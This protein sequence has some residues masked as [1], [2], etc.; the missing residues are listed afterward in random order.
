LLNNVYFDAKKGT[1]KGK[2]SQKLK[3]GPKGKRKKLN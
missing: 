3:T 1:E 2:I